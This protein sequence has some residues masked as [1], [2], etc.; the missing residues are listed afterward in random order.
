M[1][2]VDPDHFLLILRM[3]AI[4]SSFPGK[5]ILFGEHAVVYDSHAIAIPVNEVRSRVVITPLVKAAPGDVEIIAPDIH[6]SAFLKTLPDTDPLAYAIRSSLKYIGINTP[7]AFSIRIKSDI[8]IEAG[9]GSGTSV[10]CSIAKT[11]STFLGKPFPAG[12]VSSIAFE[13]EK[14]LHGTPSGVDNTVIAY[15]QP[16]Y[17]KQGD[18]KPTFLTNAARLDFLIADTGIKSR[19]SDVVGDVRRARQNDPSIY[20]RLFSRI[21]QIV[22]EA[23]QAI[24]TGQV[25]QIGSLMNEN[26]T[27]LQEMNVSH[28]RL[29]AFV[30]EAVG[31]GAFGAKLSGAGR[32]GNMIALVP[33]DK[34]K[35]VQQALQVA[36]A[37]RLIHT[38]LE[39]SS[40]ESN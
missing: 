30:A 9:M 20:D 16:V 17:F 28:P 29:D 22:T 25:A 19:T 5:I 12:I 35:A 31:N 26:H 13:V 2:V 39:P 24:K 1:G 23:Y 33:E 10:S 38:T 7:P 34:I 6:F 15:G 37:V 11:L 40:I 32:G 18:D 8:P 27:L 36:G 4:S 14:L 21:D 3:P